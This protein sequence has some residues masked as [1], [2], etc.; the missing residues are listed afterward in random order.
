MMAVGAGRL[1]Q[2]ESV[3]SI[4]AASGKNA[5]TPPNCFSEDRKII[6]PLPDFPDF[7]NFASSI[8]HHPLSSCITR[9][10]YICDKR[11]NI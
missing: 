6:R 2:P 5:G 8:L 7:N 11:C 4:A 10:F 9:D 1:T 3:T